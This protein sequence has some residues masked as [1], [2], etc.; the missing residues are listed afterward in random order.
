ML[1]NQFDYR[2]SLIFIIFNYFFELLIYFFCAVKKIA[3]KV[4]GSECPSI[5]R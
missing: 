3:P 5:L 4:K 2:K 1:V